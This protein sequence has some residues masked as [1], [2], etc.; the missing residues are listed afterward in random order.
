MIC[1][2]VLCLFS[3]SYDPEQKALELVPINQKIIMPEQITYKV[4]YQSVFKT[5]CLNCHS[6]SAGNKGGINLEN[7]ESIAK[8][9]AL[10]RKEVAGKTMP[11]RGG[12]S[13]DQIKL[14]IDWIDA[15]AHEHG[16]MAGEA[17]VPPAP[18]PAPP[19]PAPAI[20]FT[21]IQSLVLKTNCLEC[22]SEIG[23]NRG[24]VNLETYRNVFE[25]RIEIKDEIESGR[26]PTKKGTPLT[27]EQK[28]LILLWLASGSPE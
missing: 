27:T 2:T 8:N 14:V 10:I 6:S 1:T 5:A 13:E 24:D 18:Q 11:P 15:G 21:K 3:C 20:T 26:M 7:F 19:A 12:L 28:N 9:A 4:V 22:H 16:S 23:G 25:S 17:P